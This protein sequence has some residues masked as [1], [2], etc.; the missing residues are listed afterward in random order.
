MN[1]MQLKV[2]ELR[3]SGGMRSIRMWGLVARE[4]VRVMID[5]GASHNLVYQ[6]LVKRLG[7][8]V[9][10]TFEF[11]VKVGN[12]QQVW[13]MG[14]CKDVQIQFPESM[15]QQNLSLFPVEGAEVVMGLAWLDTLGD[16]RANFKE[17]KLQFWVNGVK[18]ALKGDADL[19][20][21]GFL[22]DL[23]G[24]QFKRRVMGC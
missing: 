19:C 20:Y 22:T 5:I 17:C 16:V 13:S 8:P 6:E 15:V 4:R 10:H 12:G 1:S 9:L 23:L 11:S 2:S 24:R 21:G 3:D 7:L 18:V 14:V